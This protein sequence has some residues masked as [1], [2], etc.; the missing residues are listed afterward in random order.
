MNRPARPVAR[1]FSLLEVL[2]TV[3]IFA[4]LFA[5]LMA[6]W[7]QALQAQERL[8]AASRQMQQQQQL[9][10]ALRQLIAGL[11]SPRVGAGVTFQGDRQGF[12]GES[13]ASL[14]PSM[15]AAPLPLTLQI[16]GSSPALA[17]HIDYPGLQGVTYPW[18]LET[19]EL[20]Y[21][22]ATG[23]SHD[24]WPPEDS[25]SGTGATSPPALPALIQ[26]TIEF[27]GQARPMTL[28]VAPRASPWQ[29]PQPRSPMGP[30]A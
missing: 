7:F 5:V 10:F 22:D 25:V 19:A 29:L 17:L 20:K 23:A 21:L 6:G 16:Q 26:F 12:T 13:A 18:K 1:G 27:A 11:V 2:I 28:L 30:M 4:L 24:Q 8:A 14:A 15:G 3:T 9:T